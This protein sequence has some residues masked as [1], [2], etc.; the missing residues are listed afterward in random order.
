[1]PETTFQKFAK[2][3]SFSETI[4]Y[5]YICQEG[6]GQTAHTIERQAVTANP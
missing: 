6:K 1:M 5:T 4:V 3:L 2:T